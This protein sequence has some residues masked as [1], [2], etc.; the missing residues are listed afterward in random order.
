MKAL[1][2]WPLLITSAALAAE[3][4][5]TQTNEPNALAPQTAAAHTNKA[6]ARP[7]LEIKAPFAEFRLKENTAIYSN[8][9]GF[10]SNN[11]VVTDPPARPGDPPTIIHCRE[12]RAKRNAAGKL[13]NIVAS[14][15]VEIDQGDNHARGQQAVYTGAN[16]TMV[17]TG[18]YPPYPQP[19]LFSSQGTNMGTEIVYDRA[20][21]KLF[22]TNAT[23]VIPS[24]TLSKAER[25]STNTIE[26]TNS[27]MLNDKRL[28]PK[29]QSPI[30]P[31]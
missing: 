19:I 26:S 28:A 14:Y 17:L 4:A 16:E 18:A 29:P 31:K 11:V 3:T 25:K 23:T 7:A 22:I 9:T 24:A 21:D 30:P 27:T 1:C 6:L 13:D 20:K 5:V 15:D 12:L 8:N 2:L 10:Y